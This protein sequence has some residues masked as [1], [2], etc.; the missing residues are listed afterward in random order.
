MKL[1]RDFMSVVSLSLILTLLS[2]VSYSKAVAG[3][4]VNPIPFVNTP[5][6][7]DSVA[8][9]GS[10]FKLTVNGTGFIS[11]SVVQ[12]NGKPLATN[13]VN[14][15]Q[16]SA[17]VP[18]ANIAVAG[19]ATVSV[20][21]P[22]PG[23]GTSNLGIFDIRKPFSAASFDYY[24]N[25]ETGSS[26]NWV[27]T[28]D[29][30]RDGKPDLIT[31]L[32][33]DNAISVS[34]GNGDGAFQPP[35]PYSVGGVPIA[36]VAVDLNNDG[37]LDL[38]V[39]RGATFVS[40]LL[41]NG[42]GTFQKQLDN[43]LGDLGA[44]LAAGDFNNDGKLD[45]AVPLSSGKVAVL[46]GNGDGTFQPQLLFDAGSNR[47]MAA[48]IGDFN[49][50]GHFDLA[51]SVF[52]DGV[53]SVLL[54]NGDGTFQPAL[55]N[56]T[57]F[58]PTTVVSA[59]L[60]GDD[61]LDLVVGS[62][63]GGFSVLLGNGDGTFHSRVDYSTDLGSFGLSTIDLNGDGKLDIVVPDLSGVTTFL[64][65]GDGTFVRRSDFATGKNRTG[66]AVQDFDG[67]GMLD[68]ATA[69]HGGSTLSLLKQVN[70]VLSRTYVKFG[71]VKVGTKSS[72]NVTMTNIGKM[73]IT[74]TEIVILGDSK[75]AYKQSNDCGSQVAPGAHCKITIAFKPTRPDPYRQARVRI[76]DS[77]VDVP[78]K[79]FLTGRGI[80]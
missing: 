54:G 59:D 19:T 43:D 7:P 60:N 66:I 9:G 70:S 17:V 33:G 4:Q 46:L 69:N 15:S 47:A 80:N 20:L 48:A 74:I 25:L 10:D 22:A 24:S 13:F 62:F 30:N 78:Q 2:G 38:V 3:N 53:V 45:L 6:V 79:I 14:G 55:T 56:Q 67:D 8:P 68:I 39:T 44:Y 27:I 29:L 35:V 26:P 18:A 1:L 75:Q 34:L 36:M 61:A 5:L 21:N 41:G 40:A 72:R 49:N 57:P 31:A 50:D 58:G 52:G 37:N 23:G 65:K 28:A 71:N 42:D 32:E 73:P 51:V 12:W 11:S 77:A 16:L 76:T 64:G 63:S